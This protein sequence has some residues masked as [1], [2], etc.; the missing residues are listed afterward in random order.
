MPSCGVMMAP[1]ATESSTWGRARW[2]G[3]GATGTAFRVWYVRLG[4]RHDERKGWMGLRGNEG[5]RA[6]RGRHRV[7]HDPCEASLLDLDG[8]VD[9]AG[10]GEC[11]EVGFE[12]ELVVLWDHAEGAKR[13]PGT[14]W[15]RKSR[16]ERAPSCMG[17][18]Q[19]WEGARSVIGDGGTRRGGADVRGRRGTPLGGPFPL[20]LDFLD[21][22]WDG[23]ASDVRAINSWAQ[24]A[25]ALDR[26]SVP[27]GGIAVVLSFGAN[28]TH[29]RRNPNPAAVTAV[30]T[31][32]VAMPAFIM[33]IAPMNEGQEAAR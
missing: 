15:E 12:A 28:S 32:T 23:A 6:G 9:L 29:Q 4:A 14:C 19:G 7:Q 24:K 25:I 27:A 3:A 13:G 30:A 22:S 31:P 33:I 18:E 1:W 26:R 21:R 2:A 20:A 10:V 16:R 8:D 17:P 5:P 11:G